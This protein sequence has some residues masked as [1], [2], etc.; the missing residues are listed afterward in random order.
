[1]PVATG[2]H[3]LPNL[4]SNSNSVG[5]DDRVSNAGPRALPLCLQRPGR[6]GEN[7]VH[8]DGSV[9]SGSC[10][11]YFCSRS[12]LLSSP[13]TACSVPMGW[14]IS[15]DQMNK[16]GLCKIFSVLHTSVLGTHFSPP[17]LSVEALQR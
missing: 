16:S 13:A 10:V 6:E 9:G 3:S 8:P 4:L 11:C 1:M 17:H 7:L 5:L 12:V 15:I 14:E 2:L